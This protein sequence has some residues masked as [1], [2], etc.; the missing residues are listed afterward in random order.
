MSAV[1]VPLLTSDLCP[2]G[3]I[4]VSRPLDRESRTF[5]TL[6]VL[7]SDNPRAPESQRR[8]AR[9]TFDL[10]VTDVN[11]HDPEWTQLVPAVSVME[12]EPV[13]TSVT[14]LRATDED[15]GSNG[16]VGSIA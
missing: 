12:S 11:D 14:D 9:K 10:T 4:T 8:T 15:I 7:A 5:Y 3:A 6:A 16:E 13:G 1:W 2:Q